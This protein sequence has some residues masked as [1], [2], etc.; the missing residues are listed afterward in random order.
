[1]NRM[2]NKHGNNISFLDSNN[3]SLKNINK[4]AFSKD[5]LEVKIF[6]NKNNK[7]FNL[8][9]LKQRTSPKI[10]KDVLSNKD[11]I[12]LKFKITD[13]VFK[14]KTSQPLR[15]IPSLK[16]SKKLY[17]RNQK[18]HI[19]L[20]KN[21]KFNPIYNVSKIRKMNWK[22]L[23]QKYPQMNPTADADFDGLINM[24]DCKPLDPS[25]DGFLSRMLGKVTGDK[26]G[27]TAEEYKEEKEFEEEQK[28]QI[29][30]V[31]KEKKIAQQETEARKKETQYQ[32]KAVKQIEEKGYAS[33]KKIKR[34]LREEKL[35]ELRERIKAKAKELSKEFKPAETL[36]G[37]LEKK[38]P[39]ITKKQAIAIK[40]KRTKGIVKTVER[41][42][43]VRGPV[44]KVAKTAKGVKRDGA[45]RPK[46]S[47]KYKDPRTGEPIT[48]IQYHKLRKQLKSQAKTVETRAEIQQRIALAKRGLSPEEVSMA[49][50]E[51]NVK[52][53]RLRALKEAKQ[54]E[55]LE[56]VPEEV[57]EQVQY[58]EVPEEVEYEEEPQ[59][60][61]FQQVQTPIQSSAQPTRSRDIPPG[62]RLQDDIMTGK[63][64][65]VPLPPQE[66]W[67]R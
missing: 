9:V 19:N 44:T 11:I 37:K 10:I 12:G 40:A 13:L 46:G 5:I 3:I 31:K 1:M 56:E 16:V 6:Q 61:E 59:V 41:F 30:E 45:G 17:N 15:I 67:T 22:Q 58:E 50:E 34:E 48:A 18:P 43:G 20:K 23:K 32:E 2:K 47:Y 36:I 25:K 64:K 65:L 66:A 52:M 57:A 26:Y 62:Y 21:M 54:Q 7:Q 35:K 53:A 14:K 39:S 28:A 51:M 55:V 60:E 29:K 8:P 24:R 27:Q 49:Q 4:K 42:A 63:K 38:I 33:S